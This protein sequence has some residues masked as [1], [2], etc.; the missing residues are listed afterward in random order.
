MPRKS[1]D[2]GMGIK[3]LGF[4]RKYSLV[5]GRGTPIA[6]IHKITNDTGLRSD[7]IDYIGIEEVVDDDVQRV[8]QF[9]PTKKY[10]FV[11]TQAPDPEMEIKEQREVLYIAGRSGS[12]KSTYAADYIQNYLE[13]F[14]ENQIYLFSDVDKDPVLDELPIIRIPLDEFLEAQISDDPEEMYTYRNFEDSLVMFDDID[15]IS[16]NLLRNHILDLRSACLQ[17]GRHCNLSMIVTRH[18]LYD[19]QKTKLLIDEANYIVV[20][21]TGPARGKINNFLETYFKWKAGRIRDILSIGS[22]WLC[23]AM[24]TPPYVIYQNGVML[25]QD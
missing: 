20:F 14:P 10:T 7:P 16:N 24:T 13:K 4:A 23:L 5:V 3:S 25:L 9:N 12:G 22:R 8:I 1:E 19:R 6:N 11:L 2:E 21:P 15:S 18:V 17:N